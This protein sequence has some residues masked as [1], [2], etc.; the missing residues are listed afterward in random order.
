MAPEDGPNLGE[1]LRRLRLARRLSLDDAAGRGGASRSALSAWETG[2]RRPRGPALVKL[3]DAYE[4]D[5]R[6][7][8]RLLHL[9]EPQQG[10][11]ALADSYLGAPVAPGGVLRTI[12]ERR[13]M[14]QGELARR[15]GVSQATVSRWE[16]GDDAPSAENIHA[17]GFALGVTAEETLALASVRG[18]AVTDLGD[19][20]EAFTAQIW[21]SEI[22]YSVREFT[23]L[24]WE[25][26]AY[27][28]AQQDPGW[29]VAL[30]SVLSLRANRLVLEERHTEIAPIVER[31][32]RLA[33]TTEARIQAV[34][35]VG[36]L[37]EADR[38]LG[39]GLARG[40]ELTGTLADRLPPSA[41]KAWM[42]RQR[43]MSL[44]RMGRTA[45][46]LDLVA[47]AAEMDI[48]E[49][50]GPYL[51]LWSHRASMIGEALLA[52]GEPKAASALVGG[53]RERGFWPHTLVAIEHANGRAATEAEM[54][55]L[56]HWAGPRDASTPLGRR[57][58]LGM[59][60]RQA[61]LTGEWDVPAGAQG[62]LLEEDDSETWD[63]LWAAVLR[64]NRG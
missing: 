31:V 11:I 7:K 51:E 1:A 23:L 8:A 10:R 42:L 43:G 62:R 13:G 35:A 16:S 54:A 17:L 34:P 6:T 18:E 27:R 15:V 30:V 32:L 36:A 21:K 49:G 12:R 29:E 14:S 28:R 25:A 33:E 26:E 44:V 22:P 59:E 3:L 45:E 64:E 61:Q 47:R 50:P 37:A 2:T 41:H 20:L 46:G 5:S 4:A 38:R 63:R 58:L 53:R 39:R 56:R 40:I 60:R 57:R 19:D 52:A 24:S 9:A 55:Y 48:E